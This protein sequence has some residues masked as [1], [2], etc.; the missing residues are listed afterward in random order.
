MLS[1]LPW[2]PRY[3]RLPCGPLCPLPSLR[4][5]GTGDPVA[6]LGACQPLLSGLPRWTGG[7][8]LAVVAN[9]ALH[10]RGTGESL[11]P[12]FS[13]R[14]HQSKGAVL[15]LGASPAH[16]ARRA[17]LPGGTCSKSH[18]NAIFFPLYNTGANSPCAPLSPTGPL[19]PCGPSGPM[20]PFPPLNPFSPGWPISPFTPSSPGS[21]MGPG[22][23][24]RPGRPGRPGSKWKFVM[25]EM[26]IEGNNCSSRSM[27]CN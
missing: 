5:G 22:D 24:G 17:L 20:D 10:A 1:V 9:L 27:I 18:L 23:P 25:Y 6:A 14:T 15:S 19:G 21:P 11:G 2:R 16:Q 8:P 12:R 26:K 7:T 13:R 4:P 3:S